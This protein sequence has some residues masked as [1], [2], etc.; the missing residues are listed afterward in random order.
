MTTNREIRKETRKV[1]SRGWF[2]R[3]FLS[4][5]ALYFVVFVVMVA[6]LSVFHD[7]EIQTWGEFLATKM[8]YLARGQDYTVPSMAVAIQMSQATLFQ[9]FLS[10]LFGAIMMFG[11][12]RITLKAVRDDMQKW[13]SSS[14]GGFA[15]PLGV[16]WLLFLMNLRVFLWSL[17]FVVPGFVAIYRYRQAWYLKSDNP[18]WGAG[19]CLAESGAMMRGLKWQA[20]CLDLSYVVKMALVFFLLCVIV[21]VSRAL[22]VPGVLSVVL[23]AVLFAVFV[24]FAMWLV[25]IGLAAMVAR[26]VFY[27]E[28]KGA[29]QGENP[30][31]GQ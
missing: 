27:R 28:A 19:K 7:M 2:G 24:L 30:V 26:A 9:Q 31:T 11:L 8:Q 22:A 16:T 13:F 4:A 12:V 10:Y 20:F 17:L 6:V 25:S 18:D 1:L 21:G 3:V 23:A 5:L 15:R 29:G 14:M